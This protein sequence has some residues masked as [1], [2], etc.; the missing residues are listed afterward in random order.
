MATITPPN[1]RLRPELASLLARLRARIRRYVAIEGLALLL[2]A[3]AGLFWLLLGL[4]YG[5]FRLTRL[6]L[7]VPLR[8]GMVVVALGLIALVA[9]AYLLLR[10]FRRMRSRALALVLERRFPELDDR[11]ILAVERAEGALA[12]DEG[13][14]SDFMLARAADDVALAAERLELADVFDRRPLRRAIL[15]AVALWVPIFALA[16]IRPGVLEVWRD[17]FVRFAE[18]YHIRDSRLALTIVAP[19]NDR[20]RALPPGSVYHHPRG[21]SLVMLLDVPAEPRDD[22]EAW[23]VPASAYASR[24]TDSGAR[25]T[26]PAIKTTDRQFRLTIEDVTESMDLWVTGGDFTTSVPYRIEVVDPPHVRR[27]RLTNY[28]PAYTRLNQRDAEGRII[29]DRQ[30]L[31]GPVASVPVGTWMNFTA[32]TNKPI[33]NARLF[34]GPHEL[35]FG[36]FS[37]DSQGSDKYRATLIL[38]GDGQQAGRRIP[39]PAG[40]AKTFIASDGR[41]I[42]VPLLVGGES[43]AYLPHGPDDRSDVPAGQAVFAIPARTPVRITFEDTHQVASLDASS[44]EIRGIPDEPP[45]IRASLRGVSN[46]ITRTAVVPVEGSI[47]DDYG[48]ETARFDYRIDD[49]QEWS[50]RPFANPPS[51]YPK[52]FTLQRDEQTPLEWLDTATLNLELGQSLRVAIAAADGDTLTGPHVARG[53]E[54][55]FTIVT[56]EELLATLYNQEINLRKRFEQSLAEMKAVRADLVAQ[57][58]RPEAKTPEETAE[59]QKS[60]QTAADR[61]FA[62]TQ[63]HAG[64]VRSVASSFEGILEQFVNNRVH[65]EN[66]LDRIRE[67]I[68][69]PLTQLGAEDFPRLDRAVGELRVQIAEREDPTDGLNNSIEAADQLIATMNAA[70]QEMQDLAEFHEAIQE[71]T[72]ILEQEQEL[73][74]RTEQEQKRSVIEGL[75]DLLE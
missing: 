10:L 13:S 35:I 46:I 63:Q 18:T 25:Q 50:S 48:L 62:E 58:D 24:R 44:F 27:V 37:E 28:Y 68:I 51:D 19:P 26:I 31:S 7:P 54:Y 43:V 9:I 57:R 47:H 69:K 55:L 32:Q 73:L 17:G 40:L 60:L 64:E 70:L 16:V 3:L 67:G 66:Q 59:F 21:A 2:A 20:L 6:E 41:S 72:H 5:Y 23:V 42:S 36:A 75:G 12:A 29:A 74:D 33:K 14:L 45:E 22:G 38:K 49:A 11:L 39:L 61:A 65:T 30:I 1:Q 4:D 8:I 53:D 52:E 34:L 15:L 56:A 71:L